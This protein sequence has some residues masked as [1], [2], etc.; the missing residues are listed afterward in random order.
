M[1]DNRNSKADPGEPIVYQIRI[2][3][4]LGSQWTEWFEGLS[5][6]LEE[7]GDML[8]TGAVVDQAALHGLLRKVRDL[9]MPLLSV[10]AVQ[11]GRTAAPVV[12]E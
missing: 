5:I 10:I 4:H 12:E 9:G 2:K 6:A 11:P 8:L 7:N 3:G 1:S